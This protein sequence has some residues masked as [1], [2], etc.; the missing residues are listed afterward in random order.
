MVGPDGKGSPVP[1]KTKADS[2]LRDVTAIKV[3]TEY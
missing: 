3:H 1:A 2:Q